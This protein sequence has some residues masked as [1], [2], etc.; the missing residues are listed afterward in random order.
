MACMMHAMELV[1]NMA[2]D[3]CTSDSYIRMVGKS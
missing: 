1:E 3:S 2:T